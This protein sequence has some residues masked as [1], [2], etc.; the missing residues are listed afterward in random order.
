MAPHPNGTPPEPL[1]SLLSAL[2]VCAQ[3]PDRYPTCEELLTSLHVIARTASDWR[4]ARPV[5]EAAQVRYRSRLNRRH[6]SALTALTRAH[7][8]ALTYCGDASAGSVHCPKA[9]SVVPGLTASPGT[10]QAEQRP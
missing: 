3:S 10:N 6:L 8:T 5:L 9:T 1:A 7:A 4:W 2:E